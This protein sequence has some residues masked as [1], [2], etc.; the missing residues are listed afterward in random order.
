MNMICVDFVHLCMHVCMNLVLG[1][2]ELLF[3]T[4]IP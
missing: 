2:V 4:D 3:S 1:G